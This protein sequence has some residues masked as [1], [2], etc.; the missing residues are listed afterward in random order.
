MPFLSHSTCTLSGSGCRIDKNFIRFL[1]G[2]KQIAHPR[3]VHPCMCIPSSH[4]LTIYSQSC[5]SD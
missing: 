2:E 3:M 1:L 4:N 5:M